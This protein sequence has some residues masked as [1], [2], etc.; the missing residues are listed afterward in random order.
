MLNHIR[1]GLQHALDFGKSS[2]IQRIERTHFVSFL[3]KVLTMIVPAII[4]GHY[5][6]EYIR[7]LQREKVLGD[8]RY[9]YILFQTISSIAIIYII[10]RI[11][12]S[13]ADEFQ[14]TSAGLFFTALFWSVQTNY[15]N[16]IKEELKIE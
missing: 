13:Y 5:N 2:K 8:K 1:L 6:D 9:K 10:Y 14:T 15:V 16:N 4:L 7:K 12:N 3:F 11:F